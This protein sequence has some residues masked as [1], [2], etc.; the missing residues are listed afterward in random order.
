MSAAEWVSFTL[1]E[2]SS[3]VINLAIPGALRPYLVYWYQQEK[4]D[5]ESVDAFILRYLGTHA[6]LVRKQT[7]QCEAT[8]DQKSEYETYLEQVE[9]DCAVE[10]DKLVG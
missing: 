2:E 5:G 8:Q 9:T 7:L 10:T 6:L 4:K 1:P 3:M